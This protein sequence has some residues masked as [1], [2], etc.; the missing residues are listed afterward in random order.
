MVVYNSIMILLRIQSECDTPIYRQLVNQVRE[1]IIF[2][3]L[4]EGERMP[5]LR[6]VASEL[7]ISYLTV[8][9]A[10]KILEQEGFLETRR[11]SGTFVSSV[12]TKTM[13]RMAI[14]ELGQEMGQFAAEAFR[15]GLSKEEFNEMANQAWDEISTNKEIR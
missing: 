13:R 1:A 12:G 11:G 5:S 2:S 7:V 15:K 10:Y 3:K 8:K 4:K 14:K 9:Q 6:E